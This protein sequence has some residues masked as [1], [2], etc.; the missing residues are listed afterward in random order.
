[1]ITR[2][3]LCGVSWSTLARLGGLVWLLIM[4]GCATPPA[5]P[6]VAAPAP[7]THLEIINRTNYAWHITISSTS[8]KETFS[9]PVQPQA[10]VK[11]DLAG[12][13]YLIEQTVTS[14]GA[15]PELSRRIPA[16]LEPGQTYRWRL[17]TLLS[18]TSG[19]P[20]RDQP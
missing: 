15:A 16:R 4:T 18:D 3:P 11:I 9:S 20:A 5:S 12:G 17:D 7:V 19:D 2:T 10:S 1:M 14:P 6:P 13:D 8:G